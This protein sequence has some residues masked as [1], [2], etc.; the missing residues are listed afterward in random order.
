MRVCGEGGGQTTFLLLLFPADTQPKKVRK[1]PPGL[2][3]SVSMGQAWSLPS[4]AWWGFH[5]RSC[6]HIPWVTGL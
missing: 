6:G 3:S 2:P 4:L 5:A 1:V